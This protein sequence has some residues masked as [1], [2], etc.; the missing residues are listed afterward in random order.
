ME[1]LCGLVAQERAG[2]SLTTLDIPVGLFMPLPAEGGGHVTARDK[3]AT[4]GRQHQVTAA[5]SLDQLV[6]RIQSIFVEFQIVFF[7]NIHVQGDS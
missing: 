3:A 7:D 2:T 6:Y 1:R 5:D 4:K